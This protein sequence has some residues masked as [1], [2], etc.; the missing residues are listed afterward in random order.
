MIV[1]SGDSI[2]TKWKTRAQAAAPD[3]TAGV[4]NPAV[5]W[6]GPT[7]DAASNWGQGVQDAVTNKRFESGVAKAGDAKWRAG[8]TQKGSQ[9]YG[10][11]V[12]ASG[13]NYQT[14]FEPFRAALA[15]ASLPARFPK[16]NPGNQQR[17]NAVAV[18]LRN[19]KLGK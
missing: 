15:S 17:S 4:S 19:V 18:L 11:G 2:A 10:Q 1:K 14:G 7:A 6:A 16:G 13:N 8:A 3:Y 12:A 9:R 5:Q